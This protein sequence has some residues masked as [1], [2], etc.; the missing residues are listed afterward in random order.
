MLGLLQ[1]TH[2]QQRYQI[3]T[4]VGT[5]GFGVV[6]KAVDLQHGNR[7]V[8]IKELR[9]RG[10]LPQAVIDATAA[11][12]REVQLL[13][14][15]RHPNLPGI[16]D[17]F[18]T[19]EYWYLVMDF[20]EGK[21]LEQCQEQAQGGRWPLSEVLDIGIQLCTVLEYLHSQQPP[22]IFR[23]LKPSNIMRTPRGH[24]YLIDFGI[25]RHF[26]PGQAKDTVALGSP[27]YAPP[28]QYGR[29]QTT[30]R[31][32][33]YSL[34]A[35]LHHLLTTHDPTEAPFQ[36]APLHSN[37]HLSI[38]E[39]GTLVMQMVEMDASKRPASMK[40]VKHELERIAHVWTAINMHFWRPGPQHTNLTR[41]GIGRFSQLQNSYS[42]Q[43]KLLK[44]V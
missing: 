11:F 19:S 13:S 39:L 21:T 31:S 1:E 42:Y 6:H 17:H 29:A 43:N 41:A 40:V 32:D 10:L 34:G 28:E 38:F 35:L 5:G 25:A 44:N 9:L 20:I 3:I 14:Q 18:T 24:L 27:G 12:K 7:L 4:Q 8:A 36:F 2:F 15:L 16:Y 37:S 33:I 30:P 22:I 26:K 23:D